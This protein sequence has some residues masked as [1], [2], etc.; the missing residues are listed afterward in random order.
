MYSSTR[1]HVA[2][3]RLLLRLLVSPGSNSLEPLY[4]SR[5]PLTDGKAGVNNVLH[6]L[7]MHLNHASNEMVLPPLLAANARGTTRLLKLLCEKLFNPPAFTRRARI[8][9]GRFGTVY[10]ATAPSCAEPLAVKLV[11][12]PSSIHEHCMLYDVYTEIAIMEML[13]SNEAIVDIVDYGVREGTYWLVMK[14]YPMSLKHWRL[15]QRVGQA[16]WRGG[17]EQRAEPAVWTTTVP[18]GPSFSPALLKV[19]CDVFRQVLTACHSLAAH[20][21]THFDLKCD[22]VLL[23]PPEAPNGRHM[24]SLADF[25]EACVGGLGTSYKASASVARGTEN[26]QSPEMLTLSKAMNSEHDEYDRRRQVACAVTCAWWRML[27]VVWV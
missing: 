27:V 19:F 18:A 25:G 5:F 16:V 24:V 8:G 21:V 17:D 1:L 4:C 6:V 3:L 13:K 12:V 9:R 10:L 22:N 14:C 11:D 7:H 20:H 26:V 15:Q 23:M 2:I